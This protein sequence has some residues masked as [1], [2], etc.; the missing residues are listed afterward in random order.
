MCCTI[1]QRLPPIFSLSPSFSFPFPLFLPPL[2]P[3]LN[4]TVKVQRLRS[5]Q[6]QPEP[7]EHFT[8]VTQV[9]NPDP[10]LTR[11]GTIQSASQQQSIH[12]VLLC[13]VD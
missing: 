8:L 1:H 3:A 6:P 7:E 13:G 10:P 2:S 4:A 9:L 11:S 5:R 12:Q